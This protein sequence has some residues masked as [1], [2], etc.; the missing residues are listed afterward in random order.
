MDMHELW[1]KTCEKLKAELP[2]ELYEQEEDVLS[3]AQFGQVA[4]KFFEKRRDKK[5]GIDAQHADAKDK[6]HPV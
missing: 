4:V 6:V 2:A 1:D 5:Y 3:Y